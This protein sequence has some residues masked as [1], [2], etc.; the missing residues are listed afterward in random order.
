VPRIVLAPVLPKPLLEVAAAL[1]PEGFDLTVADPAS[2]EFAQAMK[3]AEYFVGFARGG[4]TAEFYRN[5]PRLRLVQLISAGYDR[6]D[7]EAARQARVPVANN[8]GSN[9]VAVAEATLM[10]MLAVHKRLV[11]QHQ[12]VV[13]GK[14]RI[15]DFGENRLYELAGKT[16]GIV[17]LGT[18]GKKVARR[19]LAF[20]MSVQ[21]YDIVR[22]T[23]DQEDAMRVRFVLLPE[24]LRTSDV[25][26]LHVPLTPLTRGMM[27]R[28]EFALMKPGAFFVN[29]CRGPVVDEEALYEAL[30]TGRIAGAGLDVMVEEPPK[31]DHPLLRL[32]GSTL[33]IT[34]HTAGP[35]WENW[36]KAFRNAYDNVLRVARGERP[37]WVIPELRAELGR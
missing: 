18:I 21:Y 36:P 24:L 7:I 5:A 20:D 10:L 4:M 12:N 9:S 15:G 2:A 11:W 23:E 30:T 26:S 25:V 29:T 17:G 27:G 32:E 34:P 6:V 28:R 14:W 3:D 13:G 33:I 37:L 16:L 31:P 8:G 35:T 19:A 1:R 22:L